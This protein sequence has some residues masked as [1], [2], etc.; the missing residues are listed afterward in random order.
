[1]N[2][3]RPN[4]ILFV[5]DQQRADH[6]GCY[7]HP[8]L[9]TPAIDGLARRGVAFDNCHVAS[10]VCMPNRASLMTGRM[11]SLHGVR[12]NGIPL[13]TDA[14]T[15]VDLLRDAG[16]RTA[17]IGKSHLQNF[18]AQP[19]YAAARTGRSGFHRAGG[20]LAEASR[21]DYR[22]PA[23]RQEAPSSPSAA[24]PFYGF[25]HVDLVTG[26]GDA[27]GGD[28]ARWLSGREPDADRLLGPE[29][30]LPHE[31]VC[32]QAVRTALPEELYSTSYI[33][34]QAVSWLDAAGGAPFFLMVSFPDPHHP[35]NP[36]GRYWDAYRPEDMPVPA[37]FERNDWTAPP[38]VA[39][40]YRERD[41][42]EAA[43]QGMNSI[44][45]TLREALEAR[46]LTC[47][48][49]EMIDDAVARVLAA[50][51]R[52]GGAGRTVVAFTSDHGDHLGD[53]GLLLKGAEPYR[54]IT[55][56][57]LIWADPDGPSGVRREDMAQTVDIPATIL[58][59]ARVEPFHGMQG[60]SLLAGPVRDAAF[61]QY[62]HQRPH[63]GLGGPPRVHSLVD[64]RWRLSVFHGQDRGE[65]Y[66]LE[67]D[68][69]EFRNLW[70]D[71]GAAAEKARLMERLL[72]E[73]IAAVDRSPL[74][75]ARA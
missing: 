33:A 12:M 41:A 9:R 10:P 73:E 62:D 63:P 44:G 52:S 74:P 7:G 25:D 59:R 47:G 58:E 30:Q 6:L 71:P 40:L 26:H 45:C 27:C 66:D 69:G 24:A 19:A 75:T 53:H 38:H 72:R 34:G 70:D 20:R 21:H 23:Y 35:F 13:S 32:P 22:A 29:N 56:V 36:P 11:P 60:K 48:M 51:E 28:Y 4:F 42:G 16:Y 46:A 1:M 50:L 15:F 57:P 8:V 67:A 14:V 18:T 54:E 2:E 3:R 31:Y 65:L 17:L 55:R 43:L 49:I 68:P 64:R 39:A 5:T 37:A 61:I